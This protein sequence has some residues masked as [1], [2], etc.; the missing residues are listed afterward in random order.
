MLKMSFYV[1]VA[2]GALIE[3]V[4]LFSQ[5]PGLEERCRGGHIR[6]FSVGGILKMYRNDMWKH[7]PIV[8]QSRN[9]AF[10]FNVSNSLRFIFP[11]SLR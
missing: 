6:T 10:C 8:A 5:I 4:G 9:R 7:C 3:R 2:T 11:K 1:Y